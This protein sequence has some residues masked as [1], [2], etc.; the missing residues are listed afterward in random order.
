MTWQPG[1][2]IVS[3]SDDAE[4]LAWRK[5]QKQEQQRYRRSVYRRI[6]YY[7]SDEA[8]AVIDARTGNHAGGDYS[9]VI[10]RLILTAAGELPE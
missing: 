3:A 4:W 1:Q 8:Q 2:P 10:D 6:D 7:P 5:A 9:T